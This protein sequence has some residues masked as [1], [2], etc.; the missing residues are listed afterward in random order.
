MNAL[1][2]IIIFLM[3]T[4][5]GQ[6]R[7]VIGEFS[8]CLKKKLPC[9]WEKFKSVSGVKLEQ[10]SQG[11]FVSIKSADDV[12]A[13]SRRIGFESGEFPF[14]QWRWKAVTFP[15]GARED[16]KKKNDCAAGVYVA[17]KGN[18]PFNHILK[19]TWSTTLPVGTVLPSPFGK[20]TR[21]F[22][23][24]SGTGRR[25][26]WVTEKRNLRDDY[27]KAFGSPPP[28]IEGVALQS[29]SDNTGT[30]AE[31]DYADIVAVKE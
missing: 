2:S 1:I 21:I 19:Y 11:F 13:I 4:A 26:E 7:L 27:Q 31:A 20:N 24:E 6:D 28:P 12:Q 3:T 30:S 10:D 22:V 25:G 9:G 5:A 16:V 18:Y 8:D 14:I 15:G 17:F 23:I 29:D